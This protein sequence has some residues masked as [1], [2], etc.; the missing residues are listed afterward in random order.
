MKKTKV[1]VTRSLPLTALP[2]LSVR[3]D[4]ITPKLT[5]FLYPKNT[6]P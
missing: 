1:I 6:K 2:S 4:V 5:G 3:I